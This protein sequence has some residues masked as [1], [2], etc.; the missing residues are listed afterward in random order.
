MRCLLPL[1]LLA[2]GCLDY[3]ELGEGF[4][5]TALASGRAACDDYENDTLDAALWKP[6]VVGATLVTERYK[7][8]RLSNAQRLKAGSYN[9]PGFA[10]R[11]RGVLHASLPADIAADAQLE[12]IPPADGPIAKHAPSD[13]EPLG[14]RFFFWVGDSVSPGSYDLVRFLDASGKVQRTVSVDHGATRVTDNATG[15]TEVQGSQLFPSGWH[16]MEVDSYAHKLDVIADNHQNY[17]LA[18][19]L[20]GLAPIDALGSIQ[21]G[22][23]RGAS[24]GQPALDVWMDETIIDIAFKGVGCTP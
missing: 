4:C 16:C 1:A 9:D 23:S 24:P 2:S 22:P 6:K 10:Y 17:E 12:Y 20:S 5:T 14:V 11:G 7:G 8:G 3:D 19:G 18:Q 13:L 15:M 21:F